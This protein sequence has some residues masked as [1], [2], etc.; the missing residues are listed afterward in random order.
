M[1]EGRDEIRRRHADAAETVLGEARASVYTKDSLQMGRIKRMGACMSVLPSTVNGTELG[2]Q[3]WRD[4]LFLRYGINTPE[5]LEHC[6][7]CGPA[8]EICY[9]LDCKKG[10]LIT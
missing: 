4:P 6:N 2:A 8:F 10:G 9:A 5:L 3:E 7:G 1:G